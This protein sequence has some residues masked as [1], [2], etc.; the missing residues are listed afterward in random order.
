MFHWRPVGAGRR[1][2]WR[3][4]RE[5]LCG[6]YNLAADYRQNGFELLDLFLGNREV[7]GRQDGQVGELAGNDRSFLVFFGREPCASDRIQPQGFHAIEP[8]LLRIK[9]QP[10]DG[11]A[12]NEPV[13]RDEWVIARDTGRV[14]ARADRQ[15][16]IQH[17]LD[18]R[19][20]LGLLGAIA[21][22]EVFALKRHTILN[23][24]AA[25]QRLD[26]IDVAVGDRFAVV[27]EPVE[28]VEWNIAIDVLEDV[29]RA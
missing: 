29:Q 3:K 11:V 16:G 22:Y 26:P 14:S 27:E 10:A 18:R 19:R 8:V 9:I 17:S 7:I 4:L 15:A 6:M 5:F 2:G 20:A 24:D 23:R 13:K 1:G 25:S 21:I 12:R 28:T